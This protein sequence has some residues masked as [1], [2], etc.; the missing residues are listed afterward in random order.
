MDYAET[1]QRL[2]AQLA[3]TRAELQE[4]LDS[5][6]YCR[7]LLYNYALSNIVQGNIPSPESQEDFYRRYGISFKS[8]CFVIALLFPNAQHY[9][10]VNHLPLNYQSLREL[11]ETVEAVCAKH[12]DCLQTN[13]QM[14]F[15]LIIPVK[16]T[17]SIRNREQTRKVLNYCNAKVTKIV[18]ELINVYQLPCKAS[19][20]FPV[21]GVN[22]LAQAYDN[23]SAL[24]ESCNEK[25]Y[26]VTNY[27][28][29]YENDQ[30]QSATITLFF[31]EQNFY[32]ACINQQNIQACHHLNR[33]LNQAR[34]NINM[35]L[36]YVLRSLR[37]FML[38][39]LNK[40]NINSYKI[41]NEKDAAL[42][43]CCIDLYACATF[44]DLADTLQAFTDL[45]TQYTDHDIQANASDS[46]IDMVQNYIQAHFSDQK[47][48]VEAICAHFEISRTALSKAFK[49][50]TGATILEYIHRRRLEYAKQLIEKDIPL[51]E[52]AAGCGYYSR[53]TL[54]EV[55]KKYENTTPSAY[56]DS[57]D[58]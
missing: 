12:L 41:A 46:R 30:D 29:D 47:L 32:G 48:T 57:L 21:K 18:Q 19:I 54:T 39:L 2:Q 16:D 24:L 49:A 43:Q 35:S 5:L 13:L 53:R 17:L 40:M 15:V 11:G 14:R 9:V 51:E 26:I 20:S 38:F 34:Q 10:K 56:R 44:D 45:V 22:F 6:T 50:K 1:V 8:N 55:F 3:Q 7:H 31:L 4:S 27:M 36:S 58:I 25:Q 42:V 28:T 52:V 37:H 33:W 23:A